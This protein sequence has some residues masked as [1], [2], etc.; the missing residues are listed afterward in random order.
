MAWTAAARSTAHGMAAAGTFTVMLVLV[1][2]LSRS[3]TRLESPGRAWHLAHGGFGLL[4]LPTVFDGVRHLVPALPEKRWDPELAA[5][6]RDWLGADIPRWSER[7]LTADLADVMM[8]FYFLYFLMPLVLLAGYALNG[9]IR[10][11]Y[12]AAFVIALGLYLTYFLYLLVPAAGPRFAHP[13]GPLSEPLPEGRITGLLHD[14]I[15]DLEPQPWD[16]FP[17]AHIVLGL[18]CAGLAWPL[19]GAWRWGMAI[20]GVGTAIST[21]VLRYHWVVDL[22]AGFVVIGL[23]AGAAWALQRRA[24]AK[25][26]AS[27][28]MKSLLATDG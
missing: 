11:L 12:R 3:V 18:L 21:V 4:I 27:D 26:G 6:D 20:V 5:F 22:L 7:I 13:H 10:E 16:A 14:L 25:S 23:C 8:L 19:R 17:S 15:R 9:R 1:A 24:D 2:V 28:R